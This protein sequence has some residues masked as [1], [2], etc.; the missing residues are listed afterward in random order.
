MAYGAKKSEHAGAKHGRGAYWGRK[1]DAKKESKKIRRRDSHN[2]TE[3]EV[4]NGCI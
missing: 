2:V 3:K 1:K 4:S